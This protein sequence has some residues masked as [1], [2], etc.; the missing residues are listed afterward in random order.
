M[1]IPAIP[2]PQPAPADG[3]A[4]DG[5]EGFHHHYADVNDTHIHYVAGGTGPAVV[6][7]HG[8][9]YTWALWRRLMP[10][11]AKAGFMVIAPDLRGL[12]YSAHA[13]SG[14]SKVSVAEDIRAIVTA[15]GIGKINLVGTDI[16]TMVAYAYASRHPEEIGHLVLAESLIPG[17]G[18]EELMNPATGGYWHFGFHAQAD[19]AAFLTEGKES[20]Y[21][22]PTMSMMSTSPDATD[23]AATWFLPH[24]I[25][26]GGM[27]QGFKHYATMISDGQENRATFTGK[28]SMPV[29]VLSG[30]R[31][32]PQ[33]Q[34]LACVEKI[35]E[36][37]QT[38]LVP[39][40]GHTFSL[41]NPDWV[42]ERFV[43]FFNS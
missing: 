7:V 27:R 26:P 43:S 16:G 12:G 28:L 33:A 15:L 41:D 17:F 22:L 14:F 5:L 25:A 29:M 18:L 38:A 30:E 9:P 34:T 42:A 19:L 3:S 32:I 8:W 13:E 36:N 40:S 35:A 10:L 11:L 23:T 39:A 1:Q 24:Y 37:I 20:A 4:V 31:G 2:L 6:L 21:L